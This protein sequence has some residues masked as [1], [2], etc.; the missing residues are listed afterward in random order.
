VAAALLHDPAS[1]RLGRKPKPHDARDLQLSRYLTADRAL[2]AIPDVVDVSAG[3]TQWGMLLNDSLGDC[4]VAGALHLEMAWSKAA[5][6][7][8]VFEATNAEALRGY[9]KSCGYDPKN[10]GTDE[11][12]IERDVLRYWRKSGLGGRKVAAFV[13]VDHTSVDEM[14]AACYLFGG[15]Y[16]GVDLQV[17]QQTQQVWDY[18]RTTEWGGHAVPLVGYDVSGDGTVVTWGALKKVTAAFLAHQCN[19]AWAVLSAD[20]L[21]DKGVSP[22]GLD[23]ATLTSDLKALAAVP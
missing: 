23:L 4:T 12:G 3:I 13:A 19:E 17:A 6:H 11:G 15:V 8:P 2:P 20:L 9:E 14:R 21:D 5:G 18:D 22:A 1:V 16:L 7:H 10:P